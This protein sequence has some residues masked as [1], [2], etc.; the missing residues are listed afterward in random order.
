MNT[1]AQGE[2]G[3]CRFHPQHER[4]RAPSVEPG[5]QPGAQKVVEG[6]HTRDL[7]PDQHLSAGGDGIGSIEVLLHLGPAVPA[8]TPRLPHLRLPSM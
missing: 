6:I 7:D 8:E 2:N 5:D 4:K 1:L 3:P